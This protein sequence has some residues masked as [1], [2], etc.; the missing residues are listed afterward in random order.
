M[1]TIA[2]IGR[3]ARVHK[4]TVSRV[5]GGAEP[6]SR[7][8]PQTRERI[9]E[10]AARLGYEG[11]PLAQALRGTRSRLLGVI[12]P[13]LTHPFRATMIESIE[14]V[15]RE[16]GYYAIVGETTID[17]QGVARSRLLTTTGINALIVVG[18]S[19]LDLA[20][21]Q[22]IRETKAIVGAAAPALAERIP[23]FSIDYRTSVE[24]ALEHL[25]GLGHR[26]ITLIC[27]PETV[28]GRERIATYRRFFEARGLG[29]PRNFMYPVPGSGAVST[30]TILADG[31]ACFKSLMDRRRPPTA[32]LGG[33]SLRSIGML[34]AACSL[35]VRVPQDISILAHTDGPLVGYTTP[36]LSA[37]DEHIAEIGRDAAT[38]VLD[39]VERHREASAHLPT[40]RVRAPQ[41]VVRESTGATKERL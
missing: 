20:Q 27:S 16:R 28:E 7:F 11:N 33:G 2:D 25:V 23:T 9:L 5:L 12:V 36:A 29:V 34:R 8:N 13:T 21:V 6:A 10:A 32:I 24:L 38:Y 26:D 14:A 40:P 18:E 4:S 19:P 17:A 41:L 3:E 39:L 1:V 15:A 22:S 30:G 37:V 31:E 35:R